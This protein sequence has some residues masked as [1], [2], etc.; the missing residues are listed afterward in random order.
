M[1]DLIK[2]YQSARL[3]FISAVEKF[4]ESRRD[5]ILFGDWSLKDILVHITA[6]EKASIQK[7][8]N[9]L[10]HKKPSWISDVD[11]FNETSTREKSGASWDQ[12][13]QDFLNTGEQMIAT[14][15]KLPD[16]LWKQQTGPNPKFT[17]ERFLEAEAHH[18]QGDHLV[19]IKQFLSN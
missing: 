6:W 2:E 8:N 12:I 19:Q 10:E 5:E 16:D 4:P 9:L 18:Y 1:K 11:K 15:Q 7:I 3:I 14:Y 13:Y 17:P